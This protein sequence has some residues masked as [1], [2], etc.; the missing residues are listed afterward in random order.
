MAIPSFENP[1]RFVESDPVS[2]LIAKHNAMSEPSK[3]S[4]VEEV[5]GDFMFPYLR[6]GDMV[7]VDPC[8]DSLSDGLAVF[9]FVPGVAK[10]CRVQ[11]MPG[12]VRIFGDNKNYDEQFVSTE[13]ASLA[14]MGRVKGIFKRV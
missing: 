9:E 4:Y 12:Q 5:Q 2:A 6:S 11:L 10:V 1:R 13:R 8:N 3:D 7:L 14:L